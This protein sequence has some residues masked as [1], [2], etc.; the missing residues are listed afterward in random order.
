MVDPLRATVY[1]G[2]AA[3]GVW[4]VRRQ[5]GA[6]LL[7]TGQVFGWLG[8]AMQG[9]EVAKEVARPQTWSPWETDPGPLAALVTAPPAEGVR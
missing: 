3:F 4:L 2:W 9:Y 6:T 1:L 8:L 7:R 5:P